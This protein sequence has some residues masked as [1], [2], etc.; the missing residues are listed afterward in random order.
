MKQMMQQ[1]GEGVHPRQMSA[2][3]ET[4]RKV[5]AEFLE[6]FTKPANKRLADRE[7]LEAI[8]SASL[9]TK[10]DHKMASQLTQIVVDAI[11]CLAGEL[12]TT[13]GSAGQT[14]GQTA[15]TVSPTSLNNSL[16]KTA[17]T[18]TSDDADMAAGEE[19]IPFDLHM[20]E[21]LHM[22][23]G[24][25]SE[26][27]LVRGMVMDHGCRHPEMP[28][29]LK[30]C[31]ILT[32]NVS[33]E[34][35]KSEV[36]AGF[37]YSTAEQR[38]R[39]ALAERKFTDEKVKQIIEL[40]RKVCTPENGFTFVVLNQKGID[41][42][43]LD[44]FAKEGIMALRR[45]KRRNMERLVLCCGG[46]AVNSVED[47]TENDLGYAGEVWETEIGDDKFTFVEEVQKPKSCCI[48][49]KGS[50]EHG[51]AQV[52]DA[53]RD[54]LRAVWNLLRDKK[55]VP[56]AGAFEIACS[57]HLK[58]YANNEMTGKHKLGVMALSESLLVIPKTLARNSGFDVQDTLM[59]L[60]E[61]YA[62]QSKTDGA[63]VDIGLDLNTGNVMRPSV[64]GVYDNYIVKKQQLSLLAAVVEQLILV[65]EIMKAGKQM[66][67][68]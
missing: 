16:E 12:Q 3:L 1:T 14:E 39:L 5:A 32:C 55:V 20:V 60:Q 40:K 4:G 30:K 23:Q 46:N 64:E 36:N 22:K 41:P 26:T 33:L 11:Y 42:P 9:M 6:K 53:V 48:L 29:R 56:G 67:R 13:K 24:M 35:E 15:S 17:T 63:T 34:Y 66:G 44:M 58:D 54:G 50:T 57:A 38:E 7:M 31:K 52:Q 68:A 45:C 21:V 65:D 2:G 25:N 59:K 47:L 8:A 27:R 10:L 43:S 61:A 28:S 19:E 49:I 62:R 37:F 51:I 18:S